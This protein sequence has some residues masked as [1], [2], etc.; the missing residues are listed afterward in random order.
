MPLPMVTRTRA[1]PRRAAARSMLS[2]TLAVQAPGSYAAQANG[3]L[4]QWSSSQAPGHRTAS[5]AWLGP[6]VIMI[7]PLDLAAPSIW[8]GESVSESDIPSMA[9]QPYA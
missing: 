7:S 9:Q 3:A 2:G 8:Y 1:F 5:L 6:L 4:L